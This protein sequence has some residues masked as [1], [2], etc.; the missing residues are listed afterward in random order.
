MKN[1]F[2]TILLSAFVLWLSPSALAQ[3]GGT[4]TGGMQCYIN[5]Q[6]VFVAHGGCPASGG[7]S[8]RSNT[9]T[10]DYEAERQRQEAERQR[11]AAERK[12]QEDEIQRQEV[13]RQKR[14]AEE[15]KRRQE[16]FERNKAQAL[17]D[18][19]GISDALGLKGTDTD[20]N[21]GLKGVGG[22]STGLKDGLNSNPSPTAGAKPTECKWGDQ[23]SSVV[24]LRCLGLDPDKPIVIDWHV[25]SGQE[26]AFPA[27]ID[28]ATFQNAQY[29]SGYAALMRPGFHPSDAEEAIRHFKAAQLQ[30]PNDAL[31]RNGLYFAQLVLKGRQQREAGIKQGE[32]QLYRGIAALAAGDA[33]TA[34]DAFAQAR[35]LD[36]D[37]SQYAVYS[38]LMLGLDANYQ[39]GNK[40]ACRAVGNSLIFESLGFT[41]AEIRMLQTASRMY[42]NDVYLKTMLWRAQHLDTG[43][44]NLPSVAPAKGAFADAPSSNRQK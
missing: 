39:T 5:G 27:Q 38:R 14:V 35:Q 3:G 9:P 16:E 13:E 19:K 33:P 8:T 28:P 11:Q 37:N 31:V 42:P 40:I 20:D 41:K 10:Y 24:D 1:V 22:T 29:N 44:P 4:P 7:S 12:R 18:M 34:S 36:P 6:Y 2:G 25:V 17:H 26:R 23:G 30:R 43:N 21:F 15:A 32:Q